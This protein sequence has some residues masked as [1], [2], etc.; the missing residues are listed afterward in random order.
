M[1]YALDNKAMI[2]ITM[3]N[4]AAVLVAD[5]FDLW[6]AQARAEYDL[7]TWKFE[8]ASSNRTEFA[9]HYALNA[10]RALIAGKPVAR[11]EHKVW[12]QST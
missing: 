8:R 2:Q 10:T 5:V 11:I 4:C 7:P 1:T 3:V 6:L 12:M 9:Q